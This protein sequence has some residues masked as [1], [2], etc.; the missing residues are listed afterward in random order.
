MTG[1]TFDDNAAFH[2]PAP[3]HARYLYFP[4]A[5]EAG[6]LSVVT[7]LLH[8]DI[9]TGQNSFLTP[10]VSVEDLHESRAARNFWLQFPDAPPWSATGNSA[11]QRA[12]CE[13]EQ[14]QVALDAGFLWHRITRTSPLI[15]LRA[16]ITNFVPPSA[17]RVELMQVSISN[18]G[19]RPRT[20]APIAA[21]PL[22]GRSADNLRDHRHVT[23]LLHRI[24][25]HRYGVVVTPTLS[26]DER[27][28]QPN[29][30]RYAVLGTRSDGAAPRDFCPVLED[31][32]GARG[33]LDWP[34]A[35]VD[36]N[37]P[38][39]SAGQTFEGYEAIGA[40]RFDAATLRPGESESY[41][42]I[43]C[44]LDPDDDLDALV[45]RYGN[46]S[47]FEEWFQK[48]AEHWGDKLS[49]L[50]FHTGDAQADR[51]L[52]WVTLQPI[53]RRLFGNSFLPYHDYGR[54]GRG[55]RDLWQDCLALLM[56]EPAEVPD[57]LHSYFAGVRV[58]GSNAT[59]IGSRA[60]EFIADRNN[61]ARIWM[62]HGAWP[63]LTTKLYLDQTGDLDFLLREQTY[64]KDQ[65]VDR[66]RGIDADW[67]PDQGV[68][69][70]AQSG[71]EYRGTLLE[72][73]LVQ[74][75]TPFF[76]VGGHNNLRL[77][78]GDWNDGLDM[79]A[80]QGESV[81]FSALYA[82][83]LR[84]LS[85]LALALESRGVVSVIL[86]SELLL[87]LDT[88]SE[89]VDYQSVADKQA[90]LRDYMTAVRHTVSGRTVSVAT[91]NLA[92]DLSA[93]ADWLCEHLRRDEW[94]TNG[95][96]YHWF[97][98]YYDDDSQRVEGDHPRGVRM[99][100]AGQVFA[101][102]GD[103]A[104]ESQVDEI[105]R[106]VDHY[107]H[108]PRV[109]GYRLNTNFGEA[110]LNFGRLFG[111]AYGIKENGAM[112]THMAVMYANALYRRGRVMEA[113]NVLDG[114]YCHCLDFATSRIYPGIPEY[115]DARGRGAY[116]W[117]TGSA[118]WLLLTLLTESFG[119]RG[120]LGDL[121]L[122]PRL[123]REQFDAAGDASVETLFAGHRMR[124][125]YHNPAR[126][127]HDAYH[128]ESA[129]VDDAPVE[130]TRAADGILVARA[131]FSGLSPDAV[132]IIDVVLS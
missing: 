25:A 22:Y 53:L 124:I 130:F 16:I 109:G 62:D 96:G 33:S 103:I 36:S 1:W 95:E 118:S 39:C 67:S 30:L 48:N 78:G 4:L 66:A 90:R 128:V 74:H 82:S 131:I 114:I 104:T 129:T 50:A 2:L 43:L 49:G 29:R 77:E 70:R 81:A 99:T 27:G 45:A 122:A 11:A 132:H 98:G 61:I 24:V 52:K 55:W 31:F 35:V 19:D 65:R 32:A 125:I 12:A 93:K 54:G 56:M 7:P 8:G 112:F 37:T 97:N 6:L 42:L 58:D 60:G 3:H 69:L 117:L 106:A 23:S 126:L 101:L 92:R 10:P 57:L 102:T 120:R 89:K 86:A 84:E 94:L 87:L 100:L 40:F 121:E 80:E 9:K 71:E 26:F 72:H 63:F 113:Y 105:V 20:F 108:D 38:F 79:A 73:L 13:S 107:L 110:L 41:I 28:H 21:V 76:N 47:G 44:I 83:N 68:R 59:I 14:D 51:W 85:E 123:V 91:I 34:A 119:V 127:D 88:L 17:D 75:L 18:T 116:P 64:F 111:F 115:I 15:G 5:N 46:P